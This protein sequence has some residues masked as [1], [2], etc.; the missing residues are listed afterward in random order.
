MFLFKNQLIL[1]YFTCY[2]ISRAQIDL[3][4]LCHYQTYPPPPP[5]STK[6]NY[7]QLLKTLVTIKKQFFTE[8]EIFPV[9]P[10][11][12]FFTSN[13]VDHF[14]SPVRPVLPRVKARAPQSPFH[15]PMRNLCISLRRALP[16]Q[17]L[18]IRKDP[19]KNIE[20]QP[21]RIDGRST[22]NQPDFI[23][24]MSSRDKYAFC[25]ESFSYV[26]FARDRWP[27]KPEQF[28]PARI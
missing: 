22:K 24:N 8:A 6:K 3:E 19:T 16:I 23:C 14:L 17:I 27:C 10:V 18:I 12:F 1:L 21:F 13:L 9:L 2:T 15:L 25:Q 26:Q 4:L 5:P 11:L 7:E 28:K 20:E